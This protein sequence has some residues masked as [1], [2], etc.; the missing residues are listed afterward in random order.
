MR[1]L[2]IRFDI[3]T[4]TCLH[5]GV[6][7]LL[8]LGDR[9]GIRFTFF[10]SVGRAVSRPRALARM[11]TRSRTH[12]PRAAGYSSMRKLGIARYVKLASLNP[13][14][15]RSAPAIVARM[16]REAEVG[17]HGGRNH[18]TWQH[19]AHTWS[20]QRVADE[21]DWALAWLTEQGVGVLGF[22]SP[23]WNQP[24]G[25]SP[26]LQA[27]GFL[28]RA[29]RHGPELD[30]GLAEGPGFFN[31]ATNLVGEPGGVA[32]LEHMRAR[33]SSD[34]DILEAFRMSLRKVGDR[35]VLYD[36]PYYA[37]LHAIDLLEQMVAVAADEGRTLVTMADVARELSGERLDPSA[38]DGGGRS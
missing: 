10:L 23:G 1:T 13:E 19:A 8:D 30:G 28:Y 32:Y 4:P 2:C 18:D 38:D 9:L 20:S 27:R 35:A 12:A 31:L 11:L 34:R 33:G 36:H 21:L 25:L 22:S 6:P 14:I 24:S 29:D 17:L 16:S 3:D 26:L 5:E 37:G 15:G 7:R